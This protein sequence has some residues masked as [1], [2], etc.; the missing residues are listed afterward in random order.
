MVT[1]DVLEAEGKSG[2]AE[3]AEHVRTG[4]HREEIYY[5]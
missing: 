1:C 2:N 3:I 4:K 5:D